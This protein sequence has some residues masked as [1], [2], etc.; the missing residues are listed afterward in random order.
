MTED[1]AVRRGN[2][3]PRA[4]GCG[5]V[6]G[7][8]HIESRNSNAVWMLFAW[9]LLRARE[10]WR[11]VPSGV[12]LKWSLGWTPFGPPSRRERMMRSLH[13]LRRNASAYQA[14]N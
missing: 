7:W 2:T 3:G 6:F 12:I 1:D 9:P 5:G 11:C 14:R 10:E 4:R 13:W 8:P